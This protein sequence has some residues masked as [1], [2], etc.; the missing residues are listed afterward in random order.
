MQR[1]ST[2][3]MRAMTA[4]PSCCS[5]AVDTPARWR[6]FLAPHL[7]DL[8]VFSIALMAAMLPSPSAALATA[9]V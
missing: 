6:G 5:T 9:L 7:K 3:K 8:I 2:A 4:T 1:M